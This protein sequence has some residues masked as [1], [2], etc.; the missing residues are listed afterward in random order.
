MSFRFEL[1]ALR[2][3]H[4]AQRVAL[5]NAEDE[6]A[7]L[8]KEH[9]AQRVALRNAEAESARLRS[10]N[11][12][13]RDGL[14][15]LRR[16]AGSSS[17][18]AARPRSLAAAAA[19]VAPKKRLASAEAES[20]ASSAPPAKRQAASAGSSTA[21]SLIESAHLKP[22][23][24]AQPAQASEGAAHTLAEKARSAQLAASSARQQVRPRRRSAARGGATAET[25][26]GTPPGLVL[27]DLD[28]TLIHMLPRHD[29]PHHCAAHGLAD[30]VVDLDP[31]PDA[32]A[33]LVDTQR[34]R[35][36][37]RVGATALLEA[38]V[39][40]KFA[41]K[42]VTCNLF[43]HRIVEKIGASC[44]PPWASLHVVVITSREAGAKSV[45]GALEATGNAALEEGEER[46]ADFA[47]D[48]IAI[49]DDAP[50]AW[51]ADDVAFVTRVPRYNV[52]QKHNQGQLE[53]EQRCLRDIGRD[54][55]TRLGATIPA[56]LRP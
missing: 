14:D 34:H 56:N 22:L 30:N 38:L 9:E 4:E 47:P 20:K 5:R 2:K 15:G 31:D 55:L 42:V 46:L 19:A 16:G 40:A 13:L 11:A 54:V 43:G 23:G 27:L 50:E 8:R 37:V 45:R 21:L 35:I 28:H 12:A 39:R 24:R 44:G 51:C 41:V 1:A 36:A 18:A 32:T 26:R 53:S 48:R 33:G 49:L 52:Q 7:A 3:E 25:P 17:S 6:L 10:E 29:F